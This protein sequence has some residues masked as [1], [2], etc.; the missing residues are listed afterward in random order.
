MTHAKRRE[1]KEEPQLRADARRNREKVL[2][3][4]RELFASQGLNVGI[5]EVA[6]RA[7]VGVG[8]LYRHFPTKEDLFQATVVSH[9]EELVQFASARKSAADP[10]EA[11]FEFLKKLVEH[12]K[13]KK[14]LI[15]A[16]VRTGVEPMGKSPELSADFEEATTRLL[17]RAQRA[18][19]VRRD[20]H[21]KDIMAL[22]RGV[23]AALDVDSADARARQR[24]LEI[25][26][27][28]LRAR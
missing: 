22:I 13:A 2:E 3:A 21:F 16:L 7:G 23:F 18:G 8:T 28:G 6:R 1:E 9:I 12:G 24:M 17:S 27:N 5:D 15:D 20:V 14:N 10:G 26:S 4:A 25:I 19:A 11:F